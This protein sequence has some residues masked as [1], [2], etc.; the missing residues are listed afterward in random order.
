MTGSTRIGRLRIFATLAKFGKLGTGV[1]R[2]AMTDIDMEARQWLRRRMMESGLDAV[3]DGVGNVYGRAR[4]ARRRRLLAGIPL[5][6]RAARRL[7]R[8]RNGR[9]SSRSKSR[10]PGGQTH[11]RAAVGVDAISFADEEGTFLACL[12]SRSFCRRSRDTDLEERAQWRGRNAIPRRLAQLHSLER[13]W[14]ALDP[15]RHR[16]YFEAH[17]EQGPRL[18][19]S[20]ID[21]GVV[22]GHRRLAPPSRSFRGPSGPCRHDPDGDAARRRPWRCLHSRCRRRALPR[23]GFG[24]FRLEFRRRRRQAR[25]GQRGAER[26]GDSSS[27]SATWRR[28]DGAHGTRRSALDSPERDGADGVARDLDRDRPRSRRPTWTSG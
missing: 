25:R 6:Q 16:A 17:I 12:G 5:R 20:R 14:R 18:I 1:N 10:A 8:R 28:R 9:R 2:A 26:S 27:S 23:R 22:T 19:N 24:G 15:S 11:P 7:A 4:R 21:V 3:I 13:I